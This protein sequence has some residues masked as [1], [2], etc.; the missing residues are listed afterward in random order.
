MSPI[1]EVP[2]TF[3]PAIIAYDEVGSTNTEAMR[4]ASSGET[5]PLWISA[6]RQSAG[7]GRSGRSWQSDAGNL[8][9]SLLFTS[10]CAPAVAHQVSLLAG[11]AVHD[12]IV[13]ANAG[14][15]LRAL[16]LKW[17]NDVL[18]GTAKLAGIL[19]ESV[20]ATDGRLHIVVGIGLNLAT[21]PR[22]L[23]RETTA[24]IEQSVDMSPETMLRHVAWA[25]QSWLGVWRD[26]ADFAS[27]RSAWIARAG[28][29]G[30][31]IRVERAS[32]QLD[33]VFAGLDD[34]GAL[35]LRAPAGGMTRV[36]FG[37][38]SLQG[39]AALKGQG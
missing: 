7:R 38:V 25:T 26:G 11:V 24:L 3:E 8:Y 13:A 31:T 18:V 21:P 20:A 6:R 5:G 9:A 1:A 12:A 34:D 4:L 33:G 15:P 36:T 14:V 16:R 35:L 10:S 39:E 28:V 23:G 30:E 29:I 27:V 17:P 32:G 19:L 37:D 2:S 22:D